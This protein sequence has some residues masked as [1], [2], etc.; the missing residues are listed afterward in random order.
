[1][2]LEGFDSFH[3]NERYRKTSFVGIGKSLHIETLKFHLELIFN[4][5]QERKN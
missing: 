4:N 1:M 3:S 2:K 5:F